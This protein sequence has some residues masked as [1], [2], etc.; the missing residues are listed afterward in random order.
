MFFV[1]VLLRLMRLFRVLRP[2]LR[3]LVAT[4]P[5]RWTLVVTTRGRT[6]VA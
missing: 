6:T 4:L 3:Q 2:A 1:L 5:L